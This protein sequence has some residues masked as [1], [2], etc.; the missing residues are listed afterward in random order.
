MQA[1]ADS[2]V[3]LLLLILT[4]VILLLLLLILTHPHLGPRAKFVMTFHSPEWKSRGSD[5]SGFQ[6][7]WNF[8][9]IYFQTKIPLSPKIEKMKMN[10]FISLLL[11]QFN[12]CRKRKNRSQPK[13]FKEQV[14]QSF[15]MFLRFSFV[16]QS[17]SGFPLFFKVFGCFS[18]FPLLNSDSECPPRGLEEPPS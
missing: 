18:G 12:V 5:A 17:F 14:F 3:M 7:I 6:T 4:S 10:T 8:P 9:K 16:F 1:N 11:S 2:S 15:W 13:T